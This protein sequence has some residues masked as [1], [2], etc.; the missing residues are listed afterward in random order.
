ME[1]EVPDLAWCPDWYG[2]IQAAK[3]LGVAPWD[4]IKQSVYWRD[5]ALIAMTEEYEAQQ[6][7]NKQGK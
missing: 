2:F 7:K 4:L 3:Y 5:K 1:K 6:V